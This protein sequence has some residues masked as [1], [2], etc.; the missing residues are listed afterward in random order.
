MANVKITQL[1][2]ASSVT[3][4]DI[5]PM[6]DIGTTTTQKATLSQILALGPGQRVLWLVSGGKY[7]SLQA[8]VDA[9]S[10]G[11]VILVGP[12]PTGAPQNGTWGNVTIPAQ[13]K[14]SIVGLNGGQVS[15]AI[16]IGLVTYSPTT[17]LNINENEVFL[18]GLFINAN[19]AGTPGVTFGGTAP[20]RLRLKGCFLYNS[21]T[22]GD[23]VSVSNSAAT[24]SFYLDNCTIQTGSSNTTSILVNHQAGYTWIKNGCEFSGGGQYAMRI[25][26]GTVEASDAIF[27][28]PALVAGTASAVTT[29]TLVDA[30]KNWT[31]NAY[32]GMKVY[33][34]SATTGAGQSRT[35]IS[36]TATTLTIS[37][38]ATN[39]SP[40]PTGTITYSIG[41]PR[42]TIR[43][44]GGSAS[45]Y[46]CTVRAPI[47]DATGI[48]MTAAGVVLGINN[49]SLSVASGGATAGTGTGY[50]INGVANSFLLYGQLAYSNSAVIPY[51]VKVKNTITA[52]PVT[53][54]FTSSP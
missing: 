31:V 12:A 14:L 25:A 19:Y 38:G 46:Y 37:S 32:A 39:W 16:N 30:S 17:G 48:N 11:D 28:V 41:T 35:I 52:A 9:A 2:A 49:A 21:G 8:A 18:C 40:T 22:S 44:E 33:I 6:V 27:E 34:S 13:K 29:T 45:I 20:A 7:A 50:A 47:G 23:G 36:N 43:M 24:S 54:A 4:D 53:Q 51:N 42:E 3:L 5:V 10:A 1:P 15:T 26:G